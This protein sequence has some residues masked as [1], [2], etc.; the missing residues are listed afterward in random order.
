MF[1]RTKNIF[2]FI[3][4]FTFFTFIIRYYFSEQNIILTNKSRTNYTLL[5]IQ[6]SQNIPLLKNDTDNIIVYKDEL[7]EF[8]N[9][10]KK[11]FWENLITN[12]NE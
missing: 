10:R 12:S 9:K 2:I 1:N 3:I 6:E 7:K 8:K 11:R 4:F 5:L